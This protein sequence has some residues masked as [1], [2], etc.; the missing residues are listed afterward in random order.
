MASCQNLLNEPTEDDPTGGW[1]HDPFDNSTTGFVMNISE[2]PDFDQ[3][4]P[5]QPLTMAREL[6]R[7]GQQS[8]CPRPQRVSLAVVVATSD[9]RQP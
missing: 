6:F 3:Q 4:F 9:C 1:A 5:H 8:I 7:N 2:L